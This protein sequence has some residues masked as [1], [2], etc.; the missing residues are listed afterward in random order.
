MIPSCLAS[1]SLAEKGDR[2]D[3]SCIF[4]ISTSIS[5]SVTMGT[6]G[7]VRVGDKAPDFH[8]DAVEKGMV[9]GK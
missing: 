9:T 4:Y 7:K 5:P 6:L 3:L 2:S 8:C 1:L